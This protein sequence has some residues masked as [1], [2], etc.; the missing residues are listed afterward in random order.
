[1][2]EPINDDYKKVVF[3]KALP[4]TIGLECVFG[5]LCNNFTLEK[6]IDIL[7]RRKDVFNIE[8]Y[9]IK[10]GTQADLTLFNPE[11]NYVFSKDHILSSSKNCAFI[12]KDLKGI[13]YGSISNNKVTLNKLW[14]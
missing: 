7:T 3:D 12:D 9:P 6:T 8:N 10:V 1:M 11:K 5:I 14:T 2:H 13:V 4:G